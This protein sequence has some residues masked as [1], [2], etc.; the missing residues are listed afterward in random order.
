M[1][2]SGKRV[3]EVDVTCAYTDTSKCGNKIT[4]GGGQV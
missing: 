1:C 4:G 3:L 2:N